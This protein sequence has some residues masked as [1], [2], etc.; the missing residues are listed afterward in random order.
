MTP[1]HSVREQIADPAC[2]FALNITYQKVP[3]SFVLHLFAVDNTLDLVLQVFE[4]IF[5]NLYFSVY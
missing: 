5:R 4:C 3:S 1:H 2:L